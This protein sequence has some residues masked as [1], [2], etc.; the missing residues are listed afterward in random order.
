[1]E[2]QFPN[3]NFRIRCWVLVF[4]DERHW[5]QYEKKTIYQT[6]QDLKTEQELKREYFRDIMKQRRAEGKS[7]DT[8]KH[9]VR[10]K[11]G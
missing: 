3:Y 6:Y 8:R 7:K 4:D 10:R 11:A 9:R 2:E 1:M 5:M